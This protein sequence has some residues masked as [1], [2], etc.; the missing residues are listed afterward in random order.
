MGQYFDKDSESSVPSLVARY[1]YSSSDDDYSSSDDEEESDSEDEGPPPLM[2][3][4]QMHSDEDCD[5]ESYNGD[6]VVLSDDPY[7]SLFESVLETEYEYFTGKIIL[8]LA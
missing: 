2:P 3:R 5:L 1:D 4:D 8:L 7:R 6:P